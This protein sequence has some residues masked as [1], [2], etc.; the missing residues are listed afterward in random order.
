MSALQICLLGFGEV[1]QA[2]VPELRPRTASLT[3]WDL[4]L[5]DAASVPSRGAAQLQ[6]PAA[7]DA[8]AAVA[9]ADLVISAV[10]AAQTGEAARSAAPHLKPGAY[11]FD[12]N[13]CSPAAKQAASDP[14]E[15]AGGRFVE[16]A[17]MSPIAP[18][19]AASP[20]YLGG[21]HAAGFLAVAHSLGFTGAQV[22]SE[23]LGAASAAKMCRS[24]VVKG[25]EALMLESLLTA[26]NFGVERAVLESL[27]SMSLDDW[28]AQSRYMISRALIHGRRR[29]EEMREVARTVSEAGFAPGM[30]E[31][32]ADWQ[33]WASRRSDASP[34][35]DLESLLDRLLAT[36]NDEAAA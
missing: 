3:A 13:S 12:L 35:P 20:I 5:S 17:I 22:F 4:K 34:E 11:Y 21:K 14:I 32:C 28:R 6:V 25:L 19:N 16:A 1:G 10:T 2:L 30:S 27:Q 24:V 23:R 8:R 36:R 18:R 26:R 29:A 15:T 31:A 33:E 9:N 7:R